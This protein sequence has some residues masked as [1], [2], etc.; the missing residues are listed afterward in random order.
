MET[1]RIDLEKAKKEEE[2]E[3]DNYKAMLERV[4][5]KLKFGAKEEDEKS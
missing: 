5:G 2:Q 3:K 1:K 4:T